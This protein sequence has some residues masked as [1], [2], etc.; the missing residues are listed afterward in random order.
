MDIK[1]IKNIIQDLEDTGLGD[2]A[3]DIE[4]F[5][6]DYERLRKENARLADV[7][8]FAMGKCSDIYRYGNKV[9]KKHNAAVV[10]E[11][12]NEPAI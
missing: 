3:Y 8:E 4:K 9:M 7:V 5:V 12:K 10:S 1:E 6:K 11:I 2:Y